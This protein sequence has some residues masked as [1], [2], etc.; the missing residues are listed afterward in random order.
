M[1]LCALGHLATTSQLRSLGWTRAR[2]EA[3]PLVR[4]RRGVYACAH[5]SGPLRVAAAMGAALTCTSILSEFEVWS[6]H[7]HRP[8]LQVRPTA[9]VQPGRTQL[10]WE[11]PRFG[12]DTQ[13]RASRLQ[14]LWQAMEC[15]PVEDAIAAMES[16][17][18]KEFLTEAE[19]RRLGMHAPR[20]LQRYVPQLINN[21]GSGNETIVR[22]RLLDAG[23]SVV[24]QGPLPG[25]GHQDLVIDDIAGLEVDSARWH[26]EQIRAIDYER[27]LVSEGLG[28]PVLRILPAHVHSSWP[29]TLAVIDRMVRDARR[30]R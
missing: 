20:R 28:R 22:M 18:K 5:L 9:S 21:S 8:H 14:A 7:D 23:Y 3:A 4:V 26:G 29:H 13:W 10:H 11:L 2:L 27:D 15:L 16:A 17:I 19:V 30:R 6:G 24:P 1:D 12:M 25:A